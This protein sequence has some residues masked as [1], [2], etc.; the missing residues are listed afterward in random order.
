MT[1]VEESLSI[2]KVIV[3]QLQRKECL[4]NFCCG[5]VEI[6]KWAKNKAWKYHGQNRV[7]MFCAHLSGNDKACGFYCLSFTSES[8]NKLDNNY[9]DIYK[10]SG[11]PLIYIQ[12]L[13]VSSSIQR[14]K[15]G[16][17]LLIDALKRAYYISKNIAVYGVALRSLNERTTELYRK[18]GFTP[19][20]T[21]MYPLMILPVWT[22]M[23]LIEKNA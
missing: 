9:K 21:E 2:Q 17:F 6:D 3:K 23:D 1:N 11:V 13:A 14:Q 5:A 4:I 7:K 18:Y 8:Q 20:D 22:L 19:V 16:T 12:Y 15:L 10:N